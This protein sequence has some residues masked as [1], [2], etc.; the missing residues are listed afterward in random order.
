MIL[1][2]P[3][4]L[5]LTTIIGVA[6]AG[7]ISFLSLLIEVVKGVINVGFFIPI[8]KLIKIVKVL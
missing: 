7:A 6:L 3:C 5:P 2:L 8:Y 4:L 1:V